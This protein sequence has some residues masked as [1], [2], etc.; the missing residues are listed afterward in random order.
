[1]TGLGLQ[2]L[3]Q[4]FSERLLNGAAEGIVLAV[5]VWVLLRLTGRQNSGTRYAIWFLALLA[6]VALPFVAGMSSISSHARNVSLERLHGEIT[7]SARWAIYLFS[8]WGAVAGLL[9][10]RVGAGLWRVRG[11]RRG[12]S[13][14]NV[15]SLA[16]IISST[17]REFRSRRQVKLC[18]SGEVAVPAAVGFFRPAIVFPA[19]LLSKLSVEETRIILLHEL[20]HL[21]RWDDWTNLAQKVVKALLFFHPAVWWIENRLTL[22]RE[23]ACDDLVLE[24]T[25]SPGA[26]AA[27][28]ISFAEK[29]HSARYVALAQALVSRVNH[30]S[31]R[32]GQI[33]DV[34]RQ[35]RAGAWKAVAG[36]CAGM[37]AL[38]LCSSAYAPQL[39]AFQREAGES[40]QQRMQANSE[41]VPEGQYPAT[42]GMDVSHAQSLRPAEAR[43]IPAS[44]IAG[45]A[46]APSQLKPAIRHKTLA[47]RAISKQ[48]Q[49]PRQGMLVIMQTTR[50]DA[51]GRASWTLCIWEVE[52][53]GSTARQ[54]ESA[55]VW[56]SIQ[57]NS[58]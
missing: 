50:Y 25:V 13:E 51:M 16:P 31:L 4:V 17:L 1:M 48:R 12:F 30:M 55:I 6:I 22:E 38:V 23:M 57:M 18:V 9:L 7:L 20:A 5:I 33:L 43:A 40:P 47:I 49:L 42:Y 37:M 19:G 56:N 54:L 45:T 41:P 52:A 15:A 58:I 27:S 35:I 2:S 44:F 8:A 29:M 14:V 36:L 24:Q 39:V 32:I 53:G 11:L 10:L 26:Y 34:K 3:A 46:A 28:L 21:R